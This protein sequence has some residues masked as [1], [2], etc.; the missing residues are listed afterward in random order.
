MKTQTRPGKIVSFSPRLPSS[1]T[2]SAPPQRGFIFLQSPLPFPSLLGLLEPAPVRHRKGGCGATGSI[3]KTLSSQN[4]M[5]TTSCCTALHFSTHVTFDRK[6]V[7]SWIIISIQDD[8]APES[9]D[10]FFV[11]FGFLFFNKLRLGG[12][13]SSLDVLLCRLSIWWGDKKGLM[14]G[15]VLPLQERER[16]REVK[17]RA[18]FLRLSS[19]F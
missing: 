8:N 14:K 11:S 10:F 1:A 3:H 12:L 18:A 6:V 15:S 13:N 5:S 19:P 16:E 17:S 7:I 2:R 4:M 9:S